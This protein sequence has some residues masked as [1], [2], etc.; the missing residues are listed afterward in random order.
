MSKVFT[1]EQVNNAIACEIKYYE[2]LWK[3]GA[4][5]RSLDLKNTASHAV[6][7]LLMLK[8][9]MGLM[10]KEEVAETID[11]FNRFKETVIYELITEVAN[12][13]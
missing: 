9:H 13:N 8:E 11:D 3:K 5:S 4:Y 10:T 6:A 1:E 7:C 12:E 2:E